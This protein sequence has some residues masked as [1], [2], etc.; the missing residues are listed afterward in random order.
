[1]HWTFSLTASVLMIIGFI[2]S[3]SFKPQASGFSSSHSQ[4]GLVTVIGMFLAGTLGAWMRLWIPWLDEF[5]IRPVVWR[6]WHS[7]LGIVG[8]FLAYLAVCSGIL[9]TYKDYRMES[10]VSAF[11]IILLTLSTTY[12]LIKPIALVVK[13][14]YG[15][16]AV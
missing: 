3:L 5:D 15:L 1:M 7:I 16:F 8:Y 6:L 10:G 14:V 9:S 4:L 13:K 11:L 12:V 2:C